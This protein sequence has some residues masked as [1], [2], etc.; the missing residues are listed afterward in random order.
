MRSH[1][2]GS[3]NAEPRSSRALEVTSAG[4]RTWG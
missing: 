3:G 1:S 4:P 2:A